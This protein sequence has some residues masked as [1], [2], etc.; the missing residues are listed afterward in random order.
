MKLQPKIKI[1]IT[2]SLGILIT[3]AILLFLVKNEYSNL[4]TI[5]A[6]L[7]EKSNNLRLAQDKLAS[8]QRQSKQSEEITSIKDICLSQL[9]QEL[10]ATA[11]VS[12]LEK[13]GQSIQV[14][15]LTVSVNS[16]IASSTKKKTGPDTT[17]FN[18]TFSTPFPNVL[19][20]LEEMEKLKRLNTLSTISLTNSDN[21]LNVSASGSIYY[22]NSSNPT[23]TK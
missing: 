5:G 8:L 22:L 18:L 14:T 23:P 2:V 4:Q 9:P 12:E 15:P 21:Q 6:Q 17:T 10:E 13:L 1:L 3:T 20:F 11:F 7:S 16:T 19:K